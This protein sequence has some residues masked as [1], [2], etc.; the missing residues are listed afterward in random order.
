M[1]SRSALEKLKNA[2][3]KINVLAGSEAKEEA[4]EDKQEDK[5]K[6]EEGQEEA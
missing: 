5:K 1:C 2:G 3:C 6:A 4:A